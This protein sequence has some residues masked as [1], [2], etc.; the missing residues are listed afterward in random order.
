MADS[1]ERKRSLKLSLF[2]G[3]AESLASEPSAA[4]S[5]RCFVDGAVGLGIVAAMSKAVGVARAAVPSLSRSEPIPIVPG[6]PLGPA[7][8]RDPAARDEELSESYTCVISHV[9]GNP[10]TKRVYFGDGFHGVDANY[11]RSSGVFLGSPPPPAMEFLSRCFLCQKELH[12]LDVFM[13]RVGMGRVRFSGEFHLPG[14]HLVILQA[15]GLV[16]SV[17]V[18]VKVCA[19]FRVEMNIVLLAHSF[20]MVDW[21]WKVGGCA[22]MPPKEGKYIV[23]GSQE[24]LQHAITYPLVSCI[25]P[26]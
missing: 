13:Y 17:I 22:A 19:H 23:Q 1:S 16:V 24:R 8:Q 11:R 25:N 4:R 2:V 12:G 15:C 3:Q 10:V 21:S 26:V 5:P 6:R 18:L 7:K 14:S 20:Q 9:R